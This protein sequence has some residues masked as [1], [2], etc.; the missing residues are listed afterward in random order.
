ME[1]EGKM[2]HEELQA[3]HRR[4]KWESEIAEKELDRLHNSQKKFE[5]FIENLR[6]IEY[7]SLDALHKQ[8]R[9]Y[10]ECLILLNDHG[11]QKII[12]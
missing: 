12:S 5:T 2:T 3:E 10:S 7:S 8:Y 4:L 9:I 6:R 11:F 1:G